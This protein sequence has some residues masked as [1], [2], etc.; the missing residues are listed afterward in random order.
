MPTQHSAKEKRMALIESRRDSSLTLVSFLRAFKCSFYSFRFLVC[1][2][3]ISSSNY[4]CVSIP[5]VNIHTSSQCSSS[6]LYFRQNLLLKKI[7]FSITEINIQMKTTAAAVIKYELNYF[8]MS[9]QNHIRN[10]VARYIFCK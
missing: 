10:K 3:F 1:I 9:K 2:T 8:L 5:V 6:Q 7:Q 4:C